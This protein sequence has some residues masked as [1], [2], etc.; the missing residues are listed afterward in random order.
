MDGRCGGIG[1]GDEEYPDDTSWVAQED[2]RTRGSA[3][4]EQGRQ[5]QEEHDH[6]EKEEE[7]EELAAGGRGW[8][9]DDYLPQHRGGSG[10]RGTPGNPPASATSPRG[11][12]RWAPALRSALSYAGDDSAGGA[13]RWSGKRSDLGG[14]RDSGGDNGGDES[15]Q[16]QQQHDRRRRERER[17][18]NGGGGGGGGSYDTDTSWGQMGALASLAPAALEGALA[19]MMPGIM[20][21]VFATVAIASMNVISIVYI[22]EARP[23]LHPPRPTPHAH[24]YRICSGIEASWE[25][26]NGPAL[27]TQDYL[28]G[29]E[30]Y[31]VSSSPCS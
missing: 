3:E 14:D 28:V 26:S 23:C 24:G 7:E 31:F 25:P 15:E 29:F 13:D 12:S 10:P 27:S 5:W 21:V 20:Y 8:G 2:T 9:P 11:S 6:L 19:C 1:P 18:R 22:G 30:A 16:Q 17:R 4:Q